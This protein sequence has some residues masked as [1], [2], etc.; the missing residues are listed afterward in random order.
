MLRPY[1]HHRPPGDT[2][3]D[4]DRVARLHRRLALG[5]LP[6]VP[7]V[8]VDVYKAAQPTVGS[9]QMRLQRGVLAGEAVEQLTNTPSLQL[10]RVTPAHERA[11]RRR[12][13][14]SEE[15]TSELQSQSN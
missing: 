3:D 7:V 1:K 8:H 2:R 10:N 13:Q 9:K 14:R 4:G 11:E 5:Q 12:D 15:H 6:N